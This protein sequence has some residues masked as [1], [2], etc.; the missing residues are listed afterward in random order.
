MFNGA[1]WSSLAFETK[2]CFVFVNSREA[3]P[4]SRR[5]VIYKEGELCKLN[6]NSFC[7][8]TAWSK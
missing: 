3:L 8:V 4:G 5:V 1:S 6:L 2:Q 7:S